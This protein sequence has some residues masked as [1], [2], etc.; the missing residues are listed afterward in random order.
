MNE[1]RYLVTLTIAPCFLT[2]AIYLCLSR[3]ILTYGAHLARFRPRTYTLI[4]IC[5]DVF[6]LVLQAVGGGIADTADTKS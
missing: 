2:A 6:S 4:F 3:I 1:D 5:C